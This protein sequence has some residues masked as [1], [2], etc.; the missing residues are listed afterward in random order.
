MGKR[1]RLGFGRDMHRRR[2]ADAPFSETPCRA[3][4]ATPECW[5]GQIRPK[6]CQDTVSIFEIHCLE[7]K[8]IFGDPLLDSGVVAL[9]TLG[10]MAQAEGLGS[11]LKST[12]LRDSLQLPAL[13]FGLYNPNPLHP[14]PFTFPKALWVIIPKA[15]RVMTQVYGP[16]LRV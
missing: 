1:C 15:L 12:S 5:S 8:L 6:E 4:L 9:W 14:N 2:E 11:K 10:C 13:R 3:L 16:R 7:G